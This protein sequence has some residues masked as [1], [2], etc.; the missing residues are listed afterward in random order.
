MHSYGWAWDQ[1]LFVAHVQCLCIV[2][3]LFV[4]CLYAWR[5]WRCEAGKAQHAP[6]LAYAKAMASMGSAHPRLGWNRWLRCTCHTLVGHHAPVTTSGALDALA[7]IIGGPASPTPCH[8]LI[9]K[10][11]NSTRVL[12]RR[13]VGDS[14]H[15][16][17]ALFV[18]HVRGRFLTEFSCIVSCIVCGTRAWF[19]R[20]I[21][22]GTR[23]WFAHTCVVCIVCGTR[24]CKSIRLIT[25]YSQC[26]LPNCIF[27]K[28]N[29]SKCISSKCKV[30]RKT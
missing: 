6:Q 17:R 10:F 29:F 25:P 7:F 30:W 15:N 9:H 26:I 4:H 14:S 18:A 24:S 1:G 13:S 21:V 23:A 27:S 22:C 3:A 28:W 2:C 8:V 16:S 12:I 5:H 11:A 20:C 19:A